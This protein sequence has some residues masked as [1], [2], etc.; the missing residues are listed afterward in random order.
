MH[1][2]I[3]TAVILGSVKQAPK[4]EESD[5]KSDVDMNKNNSMYS[6]H[7]TPEMNRKSQVS[8]FLPYNTQALLK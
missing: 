4:S 2:V 1:A 3:S 7:L 5:N 6:Y 8:H